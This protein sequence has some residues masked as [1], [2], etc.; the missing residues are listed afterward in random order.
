MEHTLFLLLLLL[1]YRGNFF[2]FRSRLDGN[3]GEWS[4]LL[5]SLRELMEWVIK[6]D[7]ELSGLGPVVSDLNALRKQQV[8]IRLR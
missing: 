1:C 4:S 3:S 7:T 6:K 8:N 2:G 5:L